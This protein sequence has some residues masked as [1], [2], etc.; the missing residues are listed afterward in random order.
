MKSALKTL[1]SGGTLRRIVDTLGGTGTP[2]RNFGRI[3]FLLT[4][5]ALV[6]VV[7][8][9]PVSAA[10]GSQV[11]VQAEFNETVPA[12][13]TGEPVLL[14]KSEPNTLN[15]TFTATNQTSMYE[16]C[17]SDDTGDNVTCK[18]ESSISGEHTVQFAY[19]NLSAFEGS[20]NVTVVVRDDF[21]GR[22]ETLG[23]DTIEIR[24]IAKDG[25]I[26][27]DGLSN[28]NELKN[29]T[30]MTIRDTDRDGLEDGPEVKNYGTSPTSPD[31]DGDG[32]TD[33]QEVSIG[34][35]PR[36]VDT[37]NDG[38]NDN[39]EVRLGTDP[40]NR[41]TTMVV[42]LAGGTFF[43]VVAVWGWMALDSSGVASASLL[44][45]ETALFDRFSEDDDEPNEEEADS[46]PS[47]EFDENELLKSSQPMLSDEDRVVQL[48]R[49]NGGW[50]YQG[51]IVEET[52]WSKSK[53]S[54]LLSRMCDDGM[55]EKISVGRQNL[56]AE[57][58]SMPEGAKSPFDE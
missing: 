52:D 7:F 31:T 27:G 17:V 38:L 6:A 36:S 42:L 41:G 48:L 49:E 35:D 56:V 5:L 29:G 12:N 34:T 14:W 25:D 20:S 18:T 22:S 54:R 51:R 16:V 57:E 9:A 19:E 11:N 1:R 46:P 8:A 13:Q 23:N 55:I 10:N 26:D 39:L 37:D 15:A 44:P 43:G 2:T 58:G 45:T 47:M 28:E 33:A 4:V 24:T 40:T 21:P 30:S 32:I 53:V 50:M 3:S